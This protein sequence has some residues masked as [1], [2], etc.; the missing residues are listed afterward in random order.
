MSNCPAISSTR[1]IHITNA[2][3]T[4]TII[5]YISDIRN[6]SIQKVSYQLSHWNW[7]ILVYCFS[8]MK[9]LDVIKTYLSSNIYYLINKNPATLFKSPE[10]S[11]ISLGVN[12]I[13]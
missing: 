4:P 6:V 13:L 2:I 5:D 7:S 8:T 12:I 1:I 10:Q 11:I 9:N 3:K